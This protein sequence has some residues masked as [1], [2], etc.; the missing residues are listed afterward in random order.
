MTASKF[1]TLALSIAG[2]AESTHM[3]HPDFRLQGR[4]FASLG[5]PN[6]K[7]AMVKLT[8]AQQKQFMEAARNVFTPCKGAWGRRGATAVYLPSA[9]VALLREA[10]KQ[11][12]RNLSTRER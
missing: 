7:H 4:I 6:D 2:A 3:N 8:P 10:L 1:R 5:Y 9:R 12:A 11:A